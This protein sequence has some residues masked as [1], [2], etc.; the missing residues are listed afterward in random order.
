MTDSL[1][2]NKNRIQARL[3]ALAAIGK[4]AEGG[5]DRSFGSAAD[6]AARAHV[7]AVLKN[8]I[9]AAVSIDPAANIWAGVN[10]H[11]PLPPIAVGSHHDTVLNGGMYDGALG[12][13]L[14]IEVL[15]VVKETNYP[16][17]HPAAMVSFTAEEPNPF[18]LSTL[19]SRLATG[20]LDPDKLLQIEDTVHHISLADAL[21]KAGGSITNL[22]AARLQPG[23]LSAFIECH[24]EQGKRLDSREIPLAVVSHITGIYRETVHVCGEANHAGTTLM[25]DRHDALL[26]TSEFC[27]AFEKVLKAVNRDDVVGTIGQMELFPNSVNI[28]PGEASLT[29]EIRTPDQ[30]VLSAI[31]ADLAKCVEEI[32]TARGVSIQRS[33]LLNQDSVALDDTIMAAMVREIELM[34]EPCVTLASMAGHDATHLASITRSGMLFVRSINGK[35]HCPEEN[36]RLQDIEKAGNVLLNTILRLDKELDAE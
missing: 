4:N 23:Q 20:K 28:I 18:N 34:A 5:I 3:Q 14:A 36:S 1:S 25:N 32:E 10:E 17:R 9:G 16:L 11:S 24:I 30:A 26:T 22:T 2:V 7:I 33:V 31:L 15:Q 21:A 29:M 35:S 6:L 8:E 19:G 13:I 27:L 12:V